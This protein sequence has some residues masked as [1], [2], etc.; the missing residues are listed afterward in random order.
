M[1]ITI[2]RRTVG[3]TAAIAAT[4]LVAAAGA[5][6]G[7]QATR[8]SDTARANERNTAVSTAIAATKHADVAVL[9]SRLADQA[10]ADHQ[11]Q[12]K[13]VHAVR[14]LERKRAKRMVRAAARAARAEGYSAG[15]S[16]GYNSGYS[17]GTTN[18]LHEGSD[19]LSCSDDP[20]VTWLPFCTF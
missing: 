4:T 18:G 7:G 10:A 16:A 19:S 6:I 8:M 5:F 1:T 17:S 13:R 14:K 2:N 20:D 15:S 11:A 3:R 9:R 12:I